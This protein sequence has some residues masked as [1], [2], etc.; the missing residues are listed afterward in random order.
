MHDQ[1][2]A[3]YMEAAEKFG[4]MRDKVDSLLGTREDAYLGLLDV[5]DIGEAL[6]SRTGTLPW[7]DLTWELTLP[8]FTICVPECSLPPSA[9]IVA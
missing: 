9:S 4:S 1:A 6:S 5:P 2:Q 8:P 3:R 7:K